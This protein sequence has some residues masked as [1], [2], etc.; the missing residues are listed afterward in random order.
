MNVLKKTF[1]ISM[2]FSWLTN[3]GKRE[4]TSGDLIITDLIGQSSLL[5]T[6]KIEFLRRMESGKTY[7]LDQVDP[8]G[9]VY[10]AFV[11]NNHL[12]ILSRGEDGEIFTSD[13]RLRKEKLNGIGVSAP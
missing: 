12:V 6:E 3:C 10:E 11:I 4:P 5:M 8:Y 2:V 9:N 1:I 7:K 13:D